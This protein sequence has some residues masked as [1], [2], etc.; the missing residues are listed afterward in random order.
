M[1]TPTREEL[2]KLRETQGLT[3][4]Q[5]A[6]HYEV[7]LTTVRRWIKE[8]NIPR[9]TKQARQQRNKNISRTGEII[10]EPDD[11]MTI[12]DRAKAVLGDRLT[13][14]RG[15]GYYLDG[16]PVNSRRVI[17]GAGLK[18]LDEM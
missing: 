12:M 16:K 14:R 4:E 18:F 1:T 2:I 6:E 10:A 17:E 11:G 9:P 7:S 3:R 5:I 8:L 13:E 15:M